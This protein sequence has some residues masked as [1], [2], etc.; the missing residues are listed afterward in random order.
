MGVMENNT[1][2]GSSTGRT[3]KEMERLIPIDKFAQKMGITRSTVDRYAKA[4]RIETKEQQGQM[5]VVD[6][7]L[8]EKDWFDFGI[9]QAQARSKTRWQVACFVFAT[10]FVVVALAGAAGGVRLWTDRAASAEILAETRAQVA[11]RRLLLTALQLQVADA[12]KQIASLQE[13]LTAEGRDHAARIES[14]QAQYTAK[15]DELAKARNQLTVTTE[16]LKALQGQ[17]AAERKNY[18]ARLKSQK[19]SHAATVA[20]L[21]AS[22]SKLSGHIVE[23]SKAVA[24]VQLAP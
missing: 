20:Q 2:V 3:G 12:D 22:I 5:Y 6:K 13:Q 4:G 10:L 18:D 8:A 19:E 15:I 23:L 21:H 7:P 11:D 24:D 1:T 16:Q 9:V 17:L 14:Q